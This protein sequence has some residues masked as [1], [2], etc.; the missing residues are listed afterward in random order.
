MMHILYVEDDLKIQTQTAIY[1]RSQNHH[2]T[3]F[4]TMQAAAKF[5]IS[6]QFDLLLCDFKLPGGP[7]G[8]ALAQQ[9]RNLY[10]A[11]PIVMVSNFATVTDVSRGYEIDVDAY[12]PRPIS[13][14]DLMTKLSEAAERRQQKFDFAEVPIIR[15]SL[16]ID[17]SKRIVVWYNELLQLT[18]S[19]FALLVLLASKPGHVF[20]VTDLC[21]MTKGLRVPTSEARKLVKQHIFHLRLKLEQEGKHPQPIENV[22]GQ[23]YK[24]TLE[25]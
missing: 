5:I 21:A 14:P 20:S 17:K 11:C 13:L 3:C 24:W 18:P 25:E 4:D 23:G 15:K 22:H 2:I 16:T 10:P 12:V 6:E 8:L 1:L 9:V 7:N 19:E